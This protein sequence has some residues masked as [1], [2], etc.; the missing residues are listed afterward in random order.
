ML[1][2]TE[3]W[4]GVPRASF[5]EKRAE[6][7]GLRQLEVFGEMKELN[8]PTMDG[9]ALY[10]LRSWSPIHHQEIPSWG[11]WGGS[12]LWETPKFPE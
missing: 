2:T 5:L 1:V 10:G 3:V 4:L 6:L 11:F 9:W 8:T 12:V 7:S